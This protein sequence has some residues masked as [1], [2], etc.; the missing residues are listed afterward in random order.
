MKSILKFIRQ[1]SATFVIF[2]FLFVISVAIAFNANRFGSG[3]S[4]SVF[5]ADRSGY[6]IYLP[7]T[8]IHGF[9]AESYPEGIEAKMGY[10][11][12]IDKEHNRVFTKYP[13]GVAILTM[14]FFLIFHLAAL[15]LGYHA[16]GFSLIYYYMPSVSGP[17]Y[18]VLGLFFLYRFLRFYTE[19][20]SA[21]LALSGITLGTNLY[22]YAF[23]SPYMSHVYSFA[24]F[25]A[26]LFVLK[27]FINNGY[28]NH[29]LWALLAV[30]SGFIALT[31]PT[32]ILIIL[33]VFFLDI[34]HFK[35]F[36]ARLKQLFTLKKILLFALIFFLVISPQLIYWKYISGSY[37]HYSY[38]NESFTFLLNPRFKEVLF[39]PLNG[40]LIYNPFIGLLFI[41]LFWGVI[42]RRSNI[43]L[44]FAV[45]LVALYI[46]SAWESFHYGCS[47]G[48]RPF[49]EYLSLMALPFAL[50]INNSGK[51]IK[52]LLAL[53]GIYTV[54]FN[55]KMIYGVYIFTQCFLGDLWDKPEYL[56]GHHA[57]YR[58]W[59]WR[60]YCNC[61]EKAGIR[62]F[63]NHS[64]TWTNNF[65]SDF[66]DC[67]KTENKNTIEYKEAVSGKS[68][69]T[70]LHGISDGFIHIRG[71]KI[72]RFII[73]SIDVTAY[74]KAVERDFNA[75]LVCRIALNDTIF[76]QQSIFIRKL[77]APNTSW[78]KINHT[79]RVP[80]MGYN[81]TYSIYFQS[82][83]N[84][85]ILIDDLTL[86]FK[87]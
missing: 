45:I 50:L 18:L 54:Y 74:V 32:N 81:A 68:V 85:Q 84:K 26:F 63:R 29:I 83:E 14:P 9:K 11:F 23:V 49:A 13:A 19:K 20:W 76:H 77:I 8:F 62:P 41:A 67:F 25:A 40:M 2:L 69:A 82:P 61:V 78:Q 1:R 43:L 53:A 66:N 21:V 55:L 12:I 64:Y 65:E 52:G 39:A 38:G 59:N 36:T 42:R 70:T 22:Y 33:A 73:Q 5:W 24:L 6:Y 80:F 72:C 3:F 30:I 51:W 48:C 37:F 27:K 86:T 75:Q 58:L 7:A 60:E 15:L 87:Y 44:F 34:K 57:S 35:D 17:F 31:R 46:I 16:D 47:Y 71:E 28:K 79:F 56:S 10:G 4:Q